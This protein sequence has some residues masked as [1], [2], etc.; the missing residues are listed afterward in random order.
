MAIGKYIREKRYD[1]EP[2]ISLRQFAK[3]LGV[4]A[5]YLSDVE[6][7]RRKAS[8]DMALR[9]AAALIKTKC[10]ANRQE[11]FDRA[12]LSSGHLTAE[13]DCLNRLWGACEVL[14]TYLG[15]AIKDKKIATRIA[16]FHEQWEFEVHQALYHDFDRLL[17]DK[18]AE[19]EV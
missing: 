3:E 12:I 2:R 19:S 15:H 14:T 6:N 7:G 9:I 11:V 10:C 1:R 8:K 18:Q 17:S 5:S 4:S 13:R 16:R